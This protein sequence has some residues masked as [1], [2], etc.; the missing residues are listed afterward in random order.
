MCIRDR[1]FPLI[2]E[3]A[4]MFEPTETQ[5]LDTLNDFASSIEIIV[6]N[7]KDG[8]LDFENSPYSLPVTRPN[9]LIPAKHLTVKWG[10]FEQLDNS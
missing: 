9:E 7:V 8:S 5:S 3:E 10:D 4:L 6:N 2:I 1:Y